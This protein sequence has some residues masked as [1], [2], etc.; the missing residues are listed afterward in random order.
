MNNEIYHYRP[1]HRLVASNAVLDQLIVQLVASLGTHPE[2]ANYT[3]SLIYEKHLSYL[4]ATPLLYP[5]PRKLSGND[6]IRFC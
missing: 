4:S 1:L 6:D 2:Y 3:S 5:K